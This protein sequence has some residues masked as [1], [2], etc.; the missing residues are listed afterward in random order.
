MQFTLWWF[1]CWH[2]TLSLESLK[3][4]LPFFSRLLDCRP[5]HNIHSRALIIPQLSTHLLFLNSVPCRTHHFLIPR[6]APVVICCNKYV[7]P[8]RIS[9]HIVLFKMSFRFAF[10]L[11]LLF[12]LVFGRRGEKIENFCHSPART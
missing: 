6:L 10:F 7:F 11:S 1:I 9:C 12:Y 2:S 5:I 4:V 8:G 3:N